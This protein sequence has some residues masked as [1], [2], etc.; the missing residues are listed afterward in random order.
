MSKMAPGQHATGAP[1]FDRNTQG[2]DVARLF[3]DQVEGK[4]SECNFV[5][6][7]DLSL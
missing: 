6:S 4:H 3:K 1:V 7:S 2:S 5:V